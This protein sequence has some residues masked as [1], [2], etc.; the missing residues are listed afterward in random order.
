MNEREVHGDSDGVEVP[1]INLAL[2]GKSK[3]W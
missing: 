1:P 3:M 2:N